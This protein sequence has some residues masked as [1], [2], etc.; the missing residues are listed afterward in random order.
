MGRIE[1][2]NYFGILR[3]PQ[4]KLSPKITYL[5]ERIRSQII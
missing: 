4:D 3:Y 1:W 5:Q 2:E